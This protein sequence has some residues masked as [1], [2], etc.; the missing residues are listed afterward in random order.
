MSKYIYFTALALSLSA[1]GSPLPYSCEG[2]GG[3]A[4]FCFSDKEYKNVQASIASDF[5]KNE[6]Y[7]YIRSDYCES[8]RNAT[9]Y[10]DYYT[11]Y[12]GEKVPY[13]SDVYVCNDKSIEG[14]LEM[15]EI[16]KREE[17][18]EKLEME[19]EKQRQIEMQKK[20]DMLL[21]RTGKE[22]CDVENNG[23]RPPTPDSFPKNCLYPMSDFFSILQQTDEGTLIEL[24]DFYKR[25]FYSFGDE[26][27]FFILKN[28]VDSNMVDGQKV[29]PGYLENI[30]IFKY[31]TVT[32]AERTILKLKRH[33]DSNLDGV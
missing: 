31:I 33:T 11:F 25:L 9:I 20:E 12:N 17:Q 30:G 26:Y 29:E 4:A 1:C 5:E 32:G 15:K 18:E 8:V 2:V 10:D 3:K 6:F 14:F 21:K 13:S 22:I 16:E 24:S 23:V 7:D 28:K 19:R 27:N